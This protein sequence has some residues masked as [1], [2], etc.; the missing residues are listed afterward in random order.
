ML[1]QKSALKIASAVASVLVS[2]SYLLQASGCI[3]PYMLE[4]TASA[5]DFCF[6]FDC[7]N[8]LFGGTIDP[9]NQQPASG[10]F[11]G[12]F[13]ADCPVANAP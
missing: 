9:C 13:F 12:P 1:K 7:Q 4:S 6:I 11:T 2:G 10:Q 8:G 5:T 3:A